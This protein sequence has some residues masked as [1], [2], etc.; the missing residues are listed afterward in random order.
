MFAK[1]SRIFSSSGKAMT[2]LSSTSGSNG[3]TFGCSSGR[4]VGMSIVYLDQMPAVYAYRRAVPCEHIRAQVVDDRR[5]RRAVGPVDADRLPLPVH[6]HRVGRRPVAHG[7]VAGLPWIVKR[8]RR[9]AASAQ[10][11]FLRRIP[12]PAAILLV[13]RDAAAQ[14]R[15]AGA[16][17]RHE[18]LA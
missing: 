7:R 6:H 1:S 5:V 2:V 10:G 11:A 17:R 4:W 9:L 13:V 8:E 15:C 3:L 18:E 14:E 16:Q 12:L